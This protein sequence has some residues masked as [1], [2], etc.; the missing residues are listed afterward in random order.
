MGCWL[1]VPGEQSGLGVTADSVTRSSQYEAERDW[2]RSVHIAEGGCWWWV[3]AVGTR[4][5]VV[6]RWLQESEDEIHNNERKGSSSQQSVV[7]LSQQRS[8]GCSQPVETA[9][10]EAQ[11][12]AFSLDEFFAKKDR[13]NKKQTKKKRKGSSHTG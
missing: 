13:K 5:A 10:E 7:V 8:T 12:D 11:D 2:A 4:A 9:T 1:H 3:E 6:E